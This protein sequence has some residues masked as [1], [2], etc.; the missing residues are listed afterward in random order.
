MPEEELQLLSALLQ[1]AYLQKDEPYARQILS[2]IRFYL[3]QRTVEVLEYDESVKNYFDRLPSKREGTIRPAL[4]QSG[5]L[6]V[7]G[8][9]AVPGDSPDIP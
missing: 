1:A 4:V 3:H 7:K 2:E 9:A 8:L 5:V 6:L